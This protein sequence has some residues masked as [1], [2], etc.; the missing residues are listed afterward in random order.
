MAFSSLFLFLFALVVGE[1]FCYFCLD[2][3]ECGAVPKF[4]L[5]LSSG[6]DDVREQTVWA[7]GNIA[8]DSSD[9]RDIVLASG[10]LFPLLSQLNELSKLSMLQNATW[11]LSNFCRGKPPAPFEEVKAALPVLQRLIHANDE[12]VLTDACWALSYLS[13]G[14]NEKIQAVIEAGV[15]PRLVELLLHPSPTVF[16]PALRTIGNIVTGGD[17]SQTQF[18]IDNG[19]SPMS[20]ST[21]YKKPQEK[22]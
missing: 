18:V 12:E 22:H 9:Y 1:I 8:G 16:I 4:V 17:D 10:A 20:L 21:S 5:L 13:N 11:T 15:F 2:F 6:Y 19:G 14:P 7:L 3:P